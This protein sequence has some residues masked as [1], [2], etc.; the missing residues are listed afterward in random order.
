[1]TTQR[2]D[3]QAPSAP[4]PSRV[5]AGGGHGVMGR[6]RPWALCLWRRNALLAQEKMKEKEMND[7]FQIRGCRPG[8]QLYKPEVITRLEQEVR[9]TPESG[10]QLD[11]FPDRVDRPEMKKTTLKQ[12]MSNENQ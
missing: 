6:S 10:S 9:W 3:R 5:Q 12:N 11:A 7:G 2:Q 1:M 8:Q 4:S